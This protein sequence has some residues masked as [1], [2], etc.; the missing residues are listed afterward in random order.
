MY[1]NRAHVCFRD[2]RFVRAQR[3]ITTELV[4][5]ADAELTTLLSE[6]ARL[7]D[8]LKFYASDSNYKTDVV[9]IGVGG[10]D[11]PESDEVSIDSGRIARAAL[12]EGE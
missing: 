7:R 8:A 2:S 12:A 11:I 10:M 4:G 1:R 5:K 6:L 9:D 3:H